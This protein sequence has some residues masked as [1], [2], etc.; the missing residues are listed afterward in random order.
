MSKSE[1]R[2]SAESTSRTIIDVIY[3]LN[4]VLSAIA[5][6]VGVALILDYEEE[7]GTMIIAFT[8]IETISIILLR[9]ITNVFINIS[10]KLDTEEESL[11]RLQKIESLL[12]SISSNIKP[13]EEN[14]IVKKTKKQDTVHQ[15]ATPKPSTPQKDSTSK[16]VDVLATDFDNEVLGEIVAGNELNARRIL[17]TQKGLSLTAAIAYI[18]DIKKQM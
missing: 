11:A 7:L 3:Y 2:E 17:M 15:A 4:L 8:I 18:E 10:L 14:Q 13:A 6:I 12:R 5:I 9:A 16:N 1:I